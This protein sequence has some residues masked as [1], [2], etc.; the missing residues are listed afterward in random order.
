VGTAIVAVYRGVIGP[1]RVELG[2]SRARATRHEKVETTLIG[3]EASDIAAAEMQGSFAQVTVRFVTEQ[4]N[5][6]R[7]AEG[8]VADGNPNEVVKA[9]D[10]WTFRRDT[11]SSDP[12]WVLI[13]TESEG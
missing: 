12:N 2:E 7:D 1:L 8:Q 9:V 5:V 6:T 13:K 4:I 10:L 3:F 11:K